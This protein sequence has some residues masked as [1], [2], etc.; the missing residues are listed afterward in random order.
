MSYHATHA[1]PVPTDDHALLR[2]D[3]DGDQAAFAELVARHERM[4]FSAA[5]RILG[6]RAVAEDAAQETFLLLARRAPA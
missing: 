1:T 6:D 5:L 2:A 4:V 3:A